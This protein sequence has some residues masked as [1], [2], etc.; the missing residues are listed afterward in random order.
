MVSDNFKNISQLLLFIPLPIDLLLFF[1]N[2]TS[3]FSKSQTILKFI[4]LQYPLHTMIIY[5]FHASFI[6]FYFYY[7]R[8]RPIFK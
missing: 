1:S 2:F 4:Y 3:F 8:D 6:P 7:M 5:N